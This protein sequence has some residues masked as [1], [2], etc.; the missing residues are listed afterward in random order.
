MAF[1]VDD[2]SSVLP[3]CVD[4]IRILRLSKT[5]LMVVIYVQIAF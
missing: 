5:D 1:A 4:F 3:K 2:K